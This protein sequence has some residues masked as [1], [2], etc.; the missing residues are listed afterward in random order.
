[1]DPG[2]DFRDDYE[3]LPVARARSTP[4][5]TSAAPKFDRYQ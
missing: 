1:M 2:D 3:P 5:A 4:P